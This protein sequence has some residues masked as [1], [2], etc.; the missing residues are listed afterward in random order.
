MTTKPAYT[1]PA[2]NFTLEL[3]EEMRQRIVSLE[4]APGS[5][6]SRKE[7]QDHYGVSSTPVRDVLLRLQEDGLVEIFPQSRT[8]VSLIDLEQARQVHFLRSSVERA[9][10]YQLALKPDPVLVSVLENI[11]LLQEKNAVSDLK[12]FAALDQRF[13]RELFASA[14]LMHVYDVIRRESMHIDRIR[15]LHLPV[16]DK[17]AQILDDHRRIV[18]GVKLGDP[19]KAAKAMT[20]HLSQSIAIAGDLRDKMPAY[21]R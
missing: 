19:E 6:L 5:S 12:T 13:H 15:A 10:V 2:Q 17:V 1:P 14:R 21:F 9:L 11:V 18:D 8:V 7:L 4:F 20:L 16:G 3:A